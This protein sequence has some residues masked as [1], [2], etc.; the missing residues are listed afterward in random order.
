DKLTA[1]IEE[2]LMK[3]Q[4]KRGNAMTWTTALG[5]TQDEAGTIYDSWEDFCQEFPDGLHRNEADDQLLSQYHTWTAKEVIITD[6][7]LDWV[8]EFYNKREENKRMGQKM[9]DLEFELA[10]I[11]E[12]GRAHEHE[13]KSRSGQ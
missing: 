5:L 13:M 7:L 10:G 8:K 4:A 11:G 9:A 12:R 6:A 1:F 2:A 3:T